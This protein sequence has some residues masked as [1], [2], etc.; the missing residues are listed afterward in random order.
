MTVVIFWELSLIIGD[1]VSEFQK[2]EHA[3]KHAPSFHAPV[4]DP[5]VLQAVHSH[6]CAKTVRS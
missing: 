1:K 2:W 5:P 6:F 4:Y 3:Y